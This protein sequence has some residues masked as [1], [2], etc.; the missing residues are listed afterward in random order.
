MDKCKAYEDR[1]R[2]D[3]RKVSTLKKAESSRRYFPNGINCIGVTAQDIK[4]IVTDF[5]LDHSKLTAN[6]VLYIT[7]HLLSHAYYHEE[8]LVAFA[9]LNKF[10]NNHYDDDLLDRFEFW[11][12]NFANN[13][14]QVDDL[15]IKTIYQFLMARPHL[16][17]NT[18][19]WAYSKI[20]WCRRAS[21]VV[22]VK[23]IKRKIGKSTYYL[24]LSI[25]FKNCELLIE[26]EDEFVQKSVGWLLK[27]TSLHHEQQVIEF[28]K[29][30]YTNM[31]RPTI[32]YAIEKM[33]VQTRSH[34]L[35]F[36]K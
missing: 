34:L 15:C 4:L 19:H 27:A 20:S 35:A 25:V 30:N 12:E 21:N 3:L 23:F 29:N 9:L 36:T 8:K 10:V 5:H 16:I 2:S 13:W 17:E 7:E 6:E 11:L 24:N 14:S 18:Q 1:L 28:I 31:T 32:R 22:W 33:D 26:D